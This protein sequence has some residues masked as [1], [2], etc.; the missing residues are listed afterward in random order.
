MVSSLPLGGK[1]DKRSIE[2]GN[3]IAKKLGL[4]MISS[5][6]LYIGETYERNILV[7]KKVGKPTIKLPRRNGMAQKKP[8]T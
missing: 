3:R 6:H 5:R 8:L 7:F 1:E 4:E 2:E